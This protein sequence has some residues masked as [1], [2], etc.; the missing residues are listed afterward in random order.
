MLDIQACAIP[1]EGESLSCVKT[2]DHSSVNISGKIS[3]ENG[4]SLGNILILHK[5]ISAEAKILGMVLSCPEMALR[6]LCTQRVPPSEA[7][8]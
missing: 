6:C 4:K 5:E 8:C 1:D 7:V 3:Y 2:Y